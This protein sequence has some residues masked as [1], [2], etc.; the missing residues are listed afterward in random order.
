[1]ITSRLDI[2]HEKENKHFVLNINDEIAK[3]EYVVKND[4][5]LLVH[6]EVPYNLRGQGIGKVLVEKT[7]EKLIKEGYKAVAMRSEKW[8]TIIEY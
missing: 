7:F 3:V 6:S 1:M 5:L 8:K 4:K 2:V